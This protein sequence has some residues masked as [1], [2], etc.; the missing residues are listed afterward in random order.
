VANGSFDP[1]NSQRRIRRVVIRR[2][3]D[4]ADVAMVTSFGRIDLLDMTVRAEIGAGESW[5]HPMLSGREGAE[6]KD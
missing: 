1:R 3:R 2:G 5:S 6:L 4:A